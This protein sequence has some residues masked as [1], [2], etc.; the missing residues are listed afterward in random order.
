MS[1]FYSEDSLLKGDN[2]SLPIFI[3]VQSFWIICFLAVT[4]TFTLHFALK[5]IIYDEILATAMRENDALEQYD[6]ISLKRK[7][8][9]LERVS[10]I[11]K[12]TI[13]IA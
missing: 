5:T 4:L 8:Y 2:F 6:P 1:I 9:T 11:C 10:L 7:T 13:T 3:S 12:M